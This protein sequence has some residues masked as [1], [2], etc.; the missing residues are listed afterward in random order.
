MS[1]A[2]A[3]E[4]ARRALRLSGVE[5]Q[6]DPSDQ[7]RAKLVYQGIM[8]SP[9]CALEAWL[10]KHLRDAL[11][12]FGVQDTNTEFELTLTVPNNC[13]MPVKEAY[14]A[15]SKNIFPNASISIVREAFAAS[16]TYMQHQKVHEDINKQHTV[17]VVD[18]GDGTMDIDLERVSQTGQQL[19]CETLMTGGDADCGGRDQT[20]AFLKRMKKFLDSYYDATDV[21]KDYRKTFTLQ[22]AEEVKSCFCDRIRDYPDK[23]DFN[24]SL[25]G[26][27]KFKM[28][29]ASKETST[30]GQTWESISLSR[31]ELDG[32]FGANLKKVRGFMTDFVQRILSAQHKV[33]ITLLVGG[34]VKGYGVKDAI[35]QA[36]P[37]GG[38]AFTQD[39]FVS[40]ATGGAYWGSLAAAG[41]T[42]DKPPT[43]TVTSGPVSTSGAVARAGT[44]GAGTSTG[45]RAHVEYSDKKTPNAS[46]IVFQDTDGVMKVKKVIER[47]SPYWSRPADTAPEMPPKAPESLALRRLIY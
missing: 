35:L 39:T 20:L 34:G 19:H 12:H 23:N 31:R 5:I 26:T 27:S 30:G 32:I 36:F 47:D 14:K 43:R 28:L 25:R 6:D 4:F 38:R 44:S 22:D 46:G 18:L 41:A 45:P 29:K 2:N 16:V 21:R 42:L 13:P 33:D 8:F 37:E 9:M 1:T 17:L 15:M 11:E 3:P 40:V 24:V 7:N 10:L